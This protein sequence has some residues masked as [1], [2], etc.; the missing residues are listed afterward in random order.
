LRCAGQHQL[1]AFERLKMTNARR[2]QI[3]S[4]GLRL[5][6]ETFGT[7]API[8]FG[9]GL[10][11]NRHAVRAELAPLAGHYRIVTFDQRGHGD[12][13]AVSDPALYDPARMAG[14]ITAVMDALGIERAIVGGESMGAATALLFA[15]ANP[16]RVE[17]LLLTAPAFGDHANPAAQRLKEMGTTIA[18][19]GMD[20]FLKLAAVRQ[21]EQL[22]WSPEVI[23]YVAGQFASHDSASIAIALQTVPDWLLF[24]D[25]SPLAGLSQRAFVVA[26]DGDAIHPLAL[27]QRVTATLPNARLA[28]IATLPAIFAD[29]PA[30]GRLFQ[31][32][33]SE[34]S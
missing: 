24:D 16:Q 29:P 8:V 19:M 7:G 34:L 13:S 15:L 27:A 33:L 3:P 11:G 6:V 25:L 26:W 17:R 12:S 23:A 28:T 5:T 2:L 18:A 30:V 10:L 20:E 32:H 1:A 9:H 14:D 21:R 4:D 22:G 31:Q